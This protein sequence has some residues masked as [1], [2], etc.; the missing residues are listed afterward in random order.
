MDG[1][2]KYQVFCTESRPNEIVENMCIALLLMYGHSVGIDSSAI[3]TSIGITLVEIITKD[4]PYPDADIFTV[5]SKVS[6]GELVHPIPDFASAI[7]RKVGCA[8]SI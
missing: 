2:R 1:T 4:D 8:L 6:T 5:A 3:M 7:M